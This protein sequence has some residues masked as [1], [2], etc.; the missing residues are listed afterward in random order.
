LTT[1]WERTDAHSWRMR[2][3]PAKDTAIPLM[4]DRGRSG[5]RQRSLEQRGLEAALDFLAKIDRGRYDE[6]W[7]G[8]SERLRA[9][10]EAS[11]FAQLLRALSERRGAV[12]RRVPVA[13]FYPPVDGKNAGGPREAKVR[14]VTATEGGE[15]VEDVDLVRQAGG[16]WL[17]SGFEPR[18]PERMRQRTP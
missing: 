6:A 5:P 18:A 8:S 1:R 2:Q 12:Q 10:M 13:W 14:F 16:P 17:V 4:S 11:R 3:Q 9:S 15:G 7:N